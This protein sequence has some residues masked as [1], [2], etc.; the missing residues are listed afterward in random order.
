V[1]IEHGIQQRAVEID[2]HGAYGERCR[3]SRH[4]QLRAQRGD[5]AVV[6][7]GVAVPAGAEDRRT[8]DESVGA[9]AGD[10]GNVVDL[11]PAI[12]L[13]A[14][15]PPAGALVGV[16]SGACGLEFGQRRGNELLPAKAG[17]TL[18]SRMISSLSMT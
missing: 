10:L 14:D 9:G 6:A 15:S 13:E 2:Q 3:A 4:R 18:I 17:L 16:D 5:D 7:V 8:G 1:Q 11:H 12:D